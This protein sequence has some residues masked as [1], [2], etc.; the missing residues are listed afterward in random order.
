MIFIYN[1][2]PS[3]TIVKMQNCMWNSCGASV[4]PSPMPRP[5]TS[6][7]L[8]ANYVRG[9]SKDSVEALFPDSNFLKGFL[10]GFWLYDLFYD[11]FIILWPVLLRPRVI[12]SEIGKYLL[13]WVPR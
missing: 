1:A 4:H 10:P 9:R 5:N 13:E 2:P 11:D 6:G 8:G 7:I 3:V 12:K